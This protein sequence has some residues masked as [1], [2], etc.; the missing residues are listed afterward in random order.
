MTVH[1]AKGNVRL[2]YFS[3]LT[4]FGT[5]HDPLLEELRIKLFF[6]AEAGSAARFQR[7]AH[8]RAAALQKVG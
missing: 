4:T 2:S 6:P 3:M 8:P 1:L 5:P 7:L